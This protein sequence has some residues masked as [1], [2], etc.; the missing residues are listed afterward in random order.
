M[1]WTGISTMKLGMDTLKITHLLAQYGYGHDYS[2]DWDLNLETGH[3]SLMNSHLVMVLTPGL[4]MGLVAH[5][6]LL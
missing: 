2:M 3:D 4:Q 1:E 6:Y 5:I